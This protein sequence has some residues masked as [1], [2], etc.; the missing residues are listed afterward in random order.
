MKLQ[1]RLEK[2]EEKMKHKTLPNNGNY[3]VYYEGTKTEAEI[4]AAKDEYIGIMEIKFR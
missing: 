4:Q 1:S 3:F 2:L